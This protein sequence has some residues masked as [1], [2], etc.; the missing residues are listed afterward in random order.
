MIARF[1]G[2]VV[3]L[4]LRVDRGTFIFDISDI[5]VVV[6][7]SV[8]Y[9]LDTAIGKSNL[10]RSGHGFTISGFRSTEFGTYEKKESGK[11]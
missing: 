2:R 5:S 6:I 11:M 1:G 3:R 9:S 7:S 4:G 8:G 10:V